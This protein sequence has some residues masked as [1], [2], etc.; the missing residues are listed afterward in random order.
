[1]TTVDCQDQILP[2]VLGLSINRSTTESPPM[3]HFEL[4]R[5]LS[6][7]WGPIDKQ[8]KQMLLYYILIMTNCPFES[9]VVGELGFIDSDSSL[10]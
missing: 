1:M 5:L 2:V 9:E 6:R 7:D 10:S 8:W 4:R 3:I